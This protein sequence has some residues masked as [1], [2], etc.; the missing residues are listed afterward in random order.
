M[1]QCCPTLRTRK[2]RYLPTTSPLQLVEGCSEDMNPQALP[3]CCI[4]RQMHQEASSGMLSTS[5]CGWDTNMISLETP[6][7]KWASF[8]VITL[9]MVS[10]PYGH[11]FLQLFLLKTYIQISYFLAQRL[12]THIL[13]LH[14]KIKLCYFLKWRVIGKAV[15]QCVFSEE[16]QQHPS[17]KV[18][19]TQLYP[20][21]WDS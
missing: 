20:M 9:K 1:S 12:A 14:L 19:S 15:E 8:Q 21:P 6:Q 7:R 5:G 10:I 13:F 2:P 11:L 16:H 18:I 17:V 4:C 3:T